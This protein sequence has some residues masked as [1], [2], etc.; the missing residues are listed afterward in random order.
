MRLSENSKFMVCGNVN[1]LRY[2]T[3][4]GISIEKL[5]QCNIEK[6]GNHYVFVLSKENKPKSKCMLPLDI[7][8]ETQPDIV[9][10]ME[11]QGEDKVKFETT[12][13]TVRVLSI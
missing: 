4:S 1:L 2:C 13:K 12:D 8:L 5:K 11:I 9:L 10:T 7:D 6:M 3:E